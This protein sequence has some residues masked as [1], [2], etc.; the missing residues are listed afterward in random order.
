[1]SAAQKTLVLNAIKTYTNDL[2]AEDEAVVLGKYQA[3]LDETYV[4]FA[5]SGTMET[6]GDYIRIDGPSIWIEYNTQGGIIIKNENHPHSVW[7][8]RKADYDNAK[9]TGVTNVATFEGAVSVFP[10][11]THQS[12]TLKITLGNSSQVAVNV[13]DMTGKLVKKVAPQQLG[14][15]EQ[16][17]AIPLENLPSGVY[18]CYIEVK[19]AQGVT[20][21]TQRVTKL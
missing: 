10:N 18:S 4:V 5:G 20:F 1:L 19:T 11:P 15:G 13:I 16:Q 21:A 12:A 9:T 3:E 2:N 7:R 17:I 14:T 8:D 6:K